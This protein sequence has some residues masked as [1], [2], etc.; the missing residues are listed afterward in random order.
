MVTD[1]AL[2]LACLAGFSWAGWRVSA[3]LLRGPGPQ[4]ATGS[5]LLAAYVL[6]AA[7]LCLVVAGLGGFG[8]FPIALLSRGS[9][10]TAAVVVVG[11]VFLA[12]PRG[13]AVGGR[14][15][16]LLRGLPPAPLLVLVG[17]LGL[18]AAFA[19]AS[20]PA[21]WDAMT[22]HLYLPSRWLAASSL[23]H[24]PTVF[25]DNAAAFAP[26]NGALLFTAT[27][28]LLQ[29]DA[30]TNVVQLVALAAIA[31]GVFSLA[32]ALGAGVGPA[33]WTAALAGFLEPLRTQVFSADVDAWLVSF[34]VAAITLLIQYLRTPRG[35]VIALAGLATG[36][37]AGTK[38]IGA[39][40][41]A[42]LFA[43]ALFVVPRG[44]RFGHLAAFLALVAVGGGCWYIRNLV[45]FRNPLFPLEFGIG[46]LR[47]PGAYRIAAVRAGE[48]H[49]GS[50][51]AVV[52]NALGVMGPLAAVLLTVG[53]AG[54]AFRAWRAGPRAAR[55]AAALLLGTG[56]LWALWFALGVPHNLEVRLLLPAAVAVLPGLAL[57]MDY[58]ASRRPRLGLAL[59]AASLGGLVLMGAPTSRWRAQL[60]VL[61][62]SGVRWEW[63][64]VA[65]AALLV[66]TSVSWIVGHRGYRRRYRIPA[67][68][69]AVVVA[70]ALVVIATRSNEASRVERYRQAD[71]GAWAVAPEVLHPHYAPSA[72]VAYTGANVPYILAGRN[73]RNVVRYVNTA[74]ALDAGFYDFWRAAGRERFPYHKP[75][76]ERITEDP[77][78][79]L[80]NLEQSEADVLVVF[81]LHPFEQR[82]LR[83]DSRGFPPE[84]DWARGRPDRFVRVWTTEFT[85]AYRIVAGPAATR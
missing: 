39:T 78:T 44:R 55:I 1:A 51:V 27:M 5:R 59:L 56:L 25:G 52:R 85:E 41:A 3:W 43:A 23:S 66:A 58:V 42:L 76:L 36:L 46:P 69:G 6:T 22:Y 30:L 50:P 24:V 35:A 8:L 19:F 75:G 34:F 57:V 74:G 16:S 53:A 38:T 40:L 60:A 82:Y 80:D 29:S 31:V 7:M 10:T 26:Q 73:F 20:A 45:S 12:C 28:L 47:F 65:T 11:I 17:V 77:R 21:D 54:L 13:A 62:A 71:F 37:A 81:R 72:R 9:F 70:L 2:L 18:D 63:I 68:A 49:L 33:A 15:A 84:S 14:P 83:H 48:F 61:E 64:L 4:V 67:L 79:W 32:R